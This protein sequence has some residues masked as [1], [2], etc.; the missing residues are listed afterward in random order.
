MIYQPASGEV[1]IAGF[2]WHQIQ[3]L[4]TVMDLG[5]LF[6]RVWLAIYENEAAT[7]FG[8]AKSPSRPVFSA[9]PSA[10]LPFGTIC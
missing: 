2:L 3:N 5:G 4:Q 10:P 9:Q 1:R 7:C 8:S 6:G